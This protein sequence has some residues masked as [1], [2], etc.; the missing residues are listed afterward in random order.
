MLLEYRGPDDVE[1]VCTV[2]VCARYS[3]TFATLSSLPYGPICT[4]KWC[5]R[6]A[7]CE[8]ILFAR[9]L[10]LRLLGAELL[11]KPETLGKSSRA[12][13][14]KRKH[15][16]QSQTEEDHSHSCTSVGRW[17]KPRKSEGQH[18]WG[19]ESEAPKG[20]GST[21]KRHQ[22]RARWSAPICRRDNPTQRPHG[23]T[24]VR[25]LARR[26]EAPTAVARYGTPGRRG[27]NPGSGRTRSTH[28]A[29][30]ASTAGGLQRVCS[31]RHSLSYQ[32]QTLSA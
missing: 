8:H 19:Q 14:Q 24:S 23:E 7:A 17:P 1:R 15:E 6:Y 18:R 30:I 28:I 11:L 4:C 22:T 12:G 20:G 5:C 21:N 31:V 29:H 26:S 10:P 3:L 13:T 16:D 32:E 27:K 2:T 9:F 25:T